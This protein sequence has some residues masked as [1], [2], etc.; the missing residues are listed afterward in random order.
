MSKY[1]KVR[2]RSKSTTFVMLRNDIIDS[3]AWLSLSAKSQALWLHIRRRY[4]GYNN[5][6][7]PL[8]C[9]EAATRLNINK[10]TA[11]QAFKE[12]Q[13]TGFLKVGEFSGFKNKRRQATRWLLTNEEFNGKPPTNEW[14]KWEEGKNLKD[15]HATGTHSPI[16]GTK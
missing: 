13:E 16:S 3:P 12:L 8:S 14:R 2:G 4:N 7:I 15:G 6:D 11:S 9:R 10:N 1:A 5:G